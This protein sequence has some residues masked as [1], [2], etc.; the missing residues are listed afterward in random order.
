MSYR[1]YTAQIVPRLCKMRSA[2]A[3]AR[4][5]ERIN[6]DIRC[7]DSDPQTAGELTERSRHATKDDRI[8]NTHRCRLANGSMREMAIRVLLLIVF[9]PAS[10]AYGQAGEPQ[11]EQMNRLLE[12]VHNRVKEAAK[13]A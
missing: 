8:H 12:G 9:L 10:Q 13:A 3:T 1:R 7:R 6:N 11:R 4:S 5:L 2:S